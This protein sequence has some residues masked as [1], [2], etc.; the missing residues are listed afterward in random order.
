[1]KII[2][3]ILL[4]ITALKIVFARNNKNALIFLSVFSMIL[5]LAYLFTNA[6]DVALTEAALGC[7]LS[8]IIYIIAIKKTSE[9][10]I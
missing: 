4:L 1:M 10:K 9:D 3:D 5:S 6:P 7:G 2:V 8:V